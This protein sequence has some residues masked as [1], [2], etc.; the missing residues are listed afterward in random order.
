MEKMSGYNLIFGCVTAKKRSIFEDIGYYNPSY[1]LIEDY[2]YNMKLLR[3]GIKIQTYDR[4]VIN[5]SKG[6]IS[7]IDC[8][9]SKYLIESDII[10]E[11]EIKP[12]VRNKLLALYKYNRWKKIVSRNKRH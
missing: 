11:N 4:I 3:N 12:Y 2:P 1:T 5:Y 7:D 8:I 10:F 6:G 9:D